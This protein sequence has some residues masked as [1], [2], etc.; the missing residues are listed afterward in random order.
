[1]VYNIKR[2]INILGVSD[3]IAKQEQL[4]YKAKALF[5]CIRTILGFL[6][7]VLQISYALP[8]K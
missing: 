1:M 6:K 5:V 8:K 2:S 3:L 7:I 4:T